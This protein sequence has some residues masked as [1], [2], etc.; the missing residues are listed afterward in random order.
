[1][2]P[3][4]HMLL[5][6]LYH[7]MPQFSFGFVFII[8]FR[9]AISLQI[10]LPCEENFSSYSVITFPSTKSASLCKSYVTVVSSH[11]GD[12]FTSSTEKSNNPLLSVLNSTYPS[13]FKISVYLSRNCLEVSLLLACLSFGHGSEKLRYILST[14]PLRIHHLYFLRPFL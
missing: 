4:S 7:Y 2:H 13:S 8:Y 1:M 12:S 11:L 10:G 5:M 6:C 3:I 9:R 14:S